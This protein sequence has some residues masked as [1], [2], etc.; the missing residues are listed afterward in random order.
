MAQKVTNFLASFA[1]KLVVKILEELANL[2]A[3]ARTQKCAN[4]GQEMSVKCRLTPP[5]LFLSLK[6]IFY[7]CVA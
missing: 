1:R 2:V 7:F 3:L 5:P 6:T 4:G